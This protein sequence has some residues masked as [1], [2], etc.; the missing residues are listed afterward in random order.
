MTNDRICDRTGIRVD[1]ASTQ[2]CLETMKP[3]A[4]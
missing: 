2:I 3:H 1:C 4:T